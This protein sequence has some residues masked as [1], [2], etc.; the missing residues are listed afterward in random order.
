MASNVGGFGII[1]FRIFGFIVGH[2]SHLR[3]KSLIISRLFFMTQMTSKEINMN[4]HFAAKDVK[5]S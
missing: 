5:A 3:M 1:V 4:G 2:F